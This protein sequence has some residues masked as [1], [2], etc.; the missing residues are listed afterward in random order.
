MDCL[1]LENY[2]T[3]WTVSVRSRIVELVK[4]AHSLIDISVVIY[5]CGYFEFFNRLGI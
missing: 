3:A 5:G 1:G 4:L 2:H